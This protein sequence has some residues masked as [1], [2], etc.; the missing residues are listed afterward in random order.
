M[1]PLVKQLFHYG[2]GF[3]AQAALTRVVVVVLALGGVHG[4]VGAGHVVQEIDGRRTLFFAVFGFSAP[5]ND[6][7]A[8][9]GLF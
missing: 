2:F 7:V 4:D 9:E 6:F 1:D 3:V 5:K 8:V